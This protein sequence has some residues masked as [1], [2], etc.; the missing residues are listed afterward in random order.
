[1]ENSNTFTHRVARAFVSGDFVHSVGD[2]VSDADWTHQGK[3]HVESMGW[4]VPLTPAEIAA[5]VVVTEIPLEDEPDV[6][7]VLDD[8]E[9]P[10]PIKPTPAKKPAKRAVKKP[11][12]E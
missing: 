7:E 1:M 5:L 4:V 9:T 10:A 12:E 11:V 8:V 3:Q 6:L 2:L